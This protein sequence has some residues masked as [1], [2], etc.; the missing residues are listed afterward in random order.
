MATIQSFDGACHGTKHVF[1][2][3]ILYC[4]NFS[5]VFLDLIMIMLIKFGGACL[6]ME[7]YGS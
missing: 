3:L 6:T 4:F 5:L 1:F 2:Y 7:Y